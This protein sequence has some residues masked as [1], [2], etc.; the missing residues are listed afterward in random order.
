MRTYV[1]IDLETTGLD[2]ERDRITEV[3][4]VRF[5]EQGTVLDTYQSLVNPGREIPY[6]IE[7]LTGVT[8]LAVRDAPA[9]AD[10]AAAFRAFVGVST[11]VGQNVGFDLFCL[12]R[13]GVPLDVSAVDTANLS[14]LLLPARQPRGLMDL[15]A[16]LGVDAA[17]HHRALP[18]AKTAAGIFTALLRRLDEIP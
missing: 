8:N 13:E 15:A 2:P 1:A 6:F 9:L 16:V 18:D 7:Q 12:R 17:E 5:D 10:I 11:L 14:R 4:A 3:G